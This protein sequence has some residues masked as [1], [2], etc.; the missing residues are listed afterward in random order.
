MSIITD[1]AATELASMAVNQ[2]ILSEE[3]FGKYKIL[4]KESGQSMVSIL[5]DKAVMD[6]F[7]LAKF[8]AQSYGLNFQEVNSDSIDEDVQSK[9]ASEY[10]RT[11]NICPFEIEGSTLKVA[12]CDQ[13]KLSLEKNIRVITGM[14]VEMVLVTITNFEKILAKFGISNAIQEVSQIGAL[15]KE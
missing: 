8:V 7:S 14:Q 11:N 9:L 3:K 1:E 10:L 2:G 12:I 13:S 4:N 5:F 6:E 15:K